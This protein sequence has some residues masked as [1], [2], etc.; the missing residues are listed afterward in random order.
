MK[1]QVIKS[2]R[3]NSKTYEVG[4]HVEIEG[5]LEGELLGIGRIAPLD[6]TEVTNRSVGLESSDEKPKKRTRAKKTT[7]KG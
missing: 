3:I 1:Y 5:F 2:C 7:A 6:E 4:D